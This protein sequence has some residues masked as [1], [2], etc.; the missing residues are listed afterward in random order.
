MSSPRSRT[1]LRRVTYV[2]L[3]I[4]VLGWALFTGWRLFGAEVAWPVAVVISYTPYIAAAILIPIAVAVWLRTIALLTVLV[5][6]ACALVV[7]L[8]PRF[9]A[10]GDGAGDGPQLRVM[11]ANVLTG[12]ADLDAIADLVVDN[13]ID[14]LTVLELDADAVDKLAKTE[15][16]DQ[17]PHQVLKPADKAAGTGIYSRH[18]LT[19]NDELAVDGLFYNPAA[20]IDVPKAGDVEFVAVHPSPPIN[21]DRTRHWRHDL[22]ALP[23]APTDGTPRILAG[24][25]NATL[26]HRILRDLIAMGYTDAADATGSGLTGTWPTDKNFPPKVTIDHVLTSTGITPTTYATHT[27]PNSDHR[28]LTT[29]MTLPKPDD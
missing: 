28:A 26:D 22:R 18:E 13:K 9:F 27:I 15:V 20:T 1:P 12:D 10:D 11:T 16:A 14:V 19:E 17:L 23:P 3:W 7:V 4:M 8:M 6:C 25:F 2:L 29:T 5:V 21:P 24:D